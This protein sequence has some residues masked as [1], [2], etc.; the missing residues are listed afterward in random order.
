MTPGFLNISWEGAHP[1]QQHDKE[2][3]TPETFS[4]CYLVP[5]MDTEIGI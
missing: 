3:N 5:K 4:G 1:Y 2:Q